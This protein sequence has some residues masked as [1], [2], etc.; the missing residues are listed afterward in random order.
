VKVALL[1]TEYA[2]P[3]LKICTPQGL[4]LY[5]PLH[6]FIIIVALH[7]KAALLETGHLYFLILLHILFAHIVLYFPLDNLSF[8]EFHVEVALTKTE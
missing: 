5:F 8:L 7:V 2:L 4:S 6:D 3:K 1:E